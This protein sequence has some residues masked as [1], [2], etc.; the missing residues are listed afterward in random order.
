MMNKA[1][2]PTSFIKS[3]CPNSQVFLKIKSKLLVWMDLKLPIMA[4]HDAFTLTDL[5]GDITTFPPQPFNRVIY[6]DKKPYD[7]R[8]KKF[9][10]IAKK[11]TYRVS[12]STS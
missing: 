3:A 10:N 2:T 5:A 7:H 6:W 8:L 11:I 9:K 12:F 4:D 1:N